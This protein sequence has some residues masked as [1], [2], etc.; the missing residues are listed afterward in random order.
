MKS[1]LIFL[2]I[3][4]LGG[5]VLAGEWH[6]NKDAENE[7]RFTSEVVVL[8]FDGVTDQIDGYIYWEGEEM[9]EKNSQ[10]QFDVD[11]NSVETGM[12]KRDRD[13]R[14]VLKT[15]KWPSTSFKGSIVKHSKIDSN[16]T[17][18]DVVAKG[19]MFI[20]GVENDIEIP[21]VITVDGDK[22]HVKVNFTVLLNDYNIEAPS[23]A[24]FVKVSEEI[25]L[26]LNFHMKDV[27]E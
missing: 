26:N 12:G 15:D 19:K 14:E 16:I 17:A 9:F 6:V 3:A 18:Y 27:T 13:M 8:T 23:L 22:I 5:S 10:M 20:H 7:V 1:L 24:A 21:G 2:F 11:L 25:I 4:Y